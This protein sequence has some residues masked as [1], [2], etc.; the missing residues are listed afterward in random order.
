MTV[1]AVQTKPWFA[2]PDENR[3]LL[4]RY[5]RLVRVGERA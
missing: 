4:R 2:R 5:C 1:A 3:V